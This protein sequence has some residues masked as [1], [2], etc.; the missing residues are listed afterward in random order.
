MTAAPRAR[1]V[2]VTGAGGFVGRR[3]LHRRPPDW[4]LVALS[5]QQLAPIEGVRMARMDAVGTALP[6]EVLEPFDALIHLAGNSDH[7]LAAR[8]PWTDVAATAGVAAAL[9]TRVATRRVVVLSSAAVYA[10]LEGPVNPD[11]CLSP[12]M[13]YALSKRYVEGLV[14]DLVRRRRV[15][16]GL[17]LRLYNVFGPGERSS[18]LIPRVVAAAREGRGFR[19]TG[20][21][22][23]L[24]DPLHIDDLVDVL[25][26]AVDSPVSGTLD[27]CGGDPTPLLDQVGRIALALDL[28]VPAIE[29]EP[30]P[31]QTPIRFWSDPV[32]TLWSL[33]LPP[34]STFAAAVRRYGHEVGWLA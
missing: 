32:P 23:A 29:S 30:D 22:S 33:G 34:F 3:V 18:R 19:L 14:G 11:L 28:P 21:P 26:A 12:T 5:R 7:G 6:P 9:L 1:R 27:V 13:P 10:G 4:D 8:E 17:V 2:L 24:S 31:D 20:D 15:E 16:G 25:I